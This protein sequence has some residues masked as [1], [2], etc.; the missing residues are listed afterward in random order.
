MLIAICISRLLV[1]RPRAASG[2]AGTNMC[3]A[4]V[5]LIVI[6]TRSQRGGMGWPEESE[7]PEDCTGTIVGSAASTR[8][9]DAKVFL[10]RGGPLPARPR[11]SAQL[12]VR[13]QRGDQF[14]GRRHEAQEG[15]LLAPQHAAPR[16]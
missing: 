8:P 12:Q 10:D 2:R 4:M 9:C 11:R 14:L 16:H 5:P 1:P 13:F 15:E 3:M 7:R 6:S